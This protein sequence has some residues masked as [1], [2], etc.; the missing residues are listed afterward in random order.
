MKIK[1]GNKFG[2]R[3]NSTW[4][5]LFVFALMPWLRK[6][7]IVD[8]VNATDDDKMKV[9]EAFESVKFKYKNEDELVQRIVMLEKKLESMQNEK[10][11]GDDDDDLSY[12][13]ADDDMNNFETITSSSDI[14]DDSI[15]LVPSWEKKRSSPRRKFNL[16]QR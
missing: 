14:N 13:S 7:R 16:K 5:L 12:M 10:N 15:A 9:Q 4:R 2:Q 1:H 6:Y 8:D 11:N 3:S